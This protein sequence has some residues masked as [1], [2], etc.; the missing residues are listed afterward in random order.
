[1]V[2]RLRGYASTAGNPG[3]I[4]GLGTNIL[5]A[6]AKKKKIGKMILQKTIKLSLVLFDLCKNYRLKKKA[7]RVCYLFFLKDD[8]HS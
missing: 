4:P 2:Q 7:G 6:V 3:S 1:M 8:C 5:H